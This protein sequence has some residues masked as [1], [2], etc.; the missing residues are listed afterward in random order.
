GYWGA[1][2]VLTAPTALSQDESSPGIIDFQR[3]VKPI[4][5]LRCLECHGP[6]EAKNDFRID[7]HESVF[8]YVEPS[9]V[10]ASSLWTDYLLSEDPDMLMPPAVAGSAQPAGLPG[11]ELAVL[12]LWI[13]E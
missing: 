10:D 2:V 1:L 11:A 3:D 7:D 5:E 13:E 8:A 4:L 6:R 9:D 12:K